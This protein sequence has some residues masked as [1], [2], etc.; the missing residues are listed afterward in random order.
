MS[1]NLKFKNFKALK[2]RNSALKNILVVKVL[3]VYMWELECGSFES[4]LML[5]EHEGLPDNSRI[6]T[7]EMED[8]QS[9]LAS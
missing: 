6:G 3:V 2:I 1:K 9:K 7:V 8:P 4:L 5:N